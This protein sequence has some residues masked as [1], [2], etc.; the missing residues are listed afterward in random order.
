MS[1]YNHDNKALEMNPNKTLVPVAICV[2][3]YQT[4]FSTNKSDKKQKSST[5]AM[6]KMDYI[7]WMIDRT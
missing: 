2:Y 5:F 3:F 1:K 7:T 6:P 4:K